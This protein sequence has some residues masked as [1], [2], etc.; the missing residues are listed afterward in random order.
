M[1]SQL[2]ISNVDLSFDDLSLRLLEKEGIEVILNGIVVSSCLIRD[3]RQKHGVLLVVQ[4]IN[5]EET[6]A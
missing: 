4:F 1:T 5:N 2:T 3:G 6:D